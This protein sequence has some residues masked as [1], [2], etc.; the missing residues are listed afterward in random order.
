MLLVGVSLLIR[1]M[2]NVPNAPSGYDTSRMLT[3]SVTSVR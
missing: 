1:T 2:V 3:M